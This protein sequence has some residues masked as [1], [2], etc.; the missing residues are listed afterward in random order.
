VTGD[1]AA[2]RLEGDAGFDWFFKFGDD[3]LVD[4]SALERVN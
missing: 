2:D 3:T 4:R 1:G